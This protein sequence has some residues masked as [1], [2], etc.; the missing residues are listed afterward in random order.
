MRTSKHVLLGLTIAAAAL[1]S[2]CGEGDGKSCTLHSDCGDLE[3]YMCFDDKC[4]L[5]PSIH[6]TDGELN[7][8]ETD[9]DCGGA[10]SSKCAVSQIC[11]INEDCDSG[12]CTN[13]RCIMKPCTLDSECPSNQCDKDKGIC[14]SC[15]DGA[16][17]G[18]E[19]DV[20]CGGKCAPCAKGKACLMPTDCQ[21]ENCTDNV[22]VGDPV[23]C[24]A[25]TL[26]DLVINEVLGSPDTA[27]P[28]ATSVSSQ[29]EFVEIVNTSNKRLDLS[30]VTLQLTKVTDSKLTSIA[31]SGC[32]AAK[33]AVVVAEG[34]IEG[35][36]SDVLWIN[37]KTAITN[38]ADYSLNLMIGDLLGESILR[39]KTTSNG[40]SQTRIPDITGGDFQLHNNALSKLVNSPGFC[41]NGGIFSKDCAIIDRCADGVK[42]DDETGVDCGGPKCAGCDDG[43]ACMQASDCLSD[44][45]EGNVCV[46]S[47]YSRPE[48]G[49]I[50]IAEVFNNVTSSSPMSVY[51][52]EV[53]TQMQV[54]YF[55]IVNLSSKALNLNGIQISTTRT[56]ATGTLAIQTLSGT[57]DPFQVIVVSDLEILGLPE[58]VKSLPLGFGNNYIT[59]TWV[60]EFSLIDNKGNVLHTAST[61]EQD[62][63]TISKALKTLSASDTELVSHN[64]I[65]QKLKHSPGYCSNGGLYVDKCRVNI[66]CANDIL[67]DDETDVD[68]G[69]PNCKA[70]S[71]GES[72]VVNEDCESSYCDNNL[73]ALSPY[74]KPVI[75]D[76][77]IAEVLNHSNTTGTLTCHD[78]SINNQP[79][80]EYYE[81]VN[82]SDKNI[83]LS[84]LKI[85]MKRLDSA[86]PSYAPQKLSG[87]LAPY[88]AVVVS[89]QKIGCLPEGVKS[90]ALG[91][92][93]NF[94]TNT[95]V[96]EI[97]LIDSEGLVLHTVSTSENDDKNKGIS[98]VIETLSTLSTNLVLHTDVG[99]N[100]ANSPGYCS[101]G[102]LYA[103][104]CMVIDLCANEVLDKDETDIDCGGPNCGACAN[105]KTCIENKDCESGYCG[106]KVCATSPYKK[107][108]AGDLIISE[109]LNNA[110]KDTPMAVYD[111]SVTNQL[112]AEYF[113]IVNLSDSVLDLNGV[114]ITSTR[115]NAT[116]DLA[117]QTL[118][119]TLEAHQAI[120]VSDQTILGLP[121]GVKSLAL[122]FGTNFIT[123]TGT[124]T[125]ELKDNEGNVLHT[126]KTIEADSAASVSKALETLDAT[127]DILKI[128]PEI[129]INDKN[130]QY[131][132]GYCSNGKLF[133]NSCL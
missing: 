5:L 20:D 109:V 31:L 129:G 15:H 23:A 25:P 39:A 38:S 74:Q 55:E 131:S 94:I 106:S 42:N 48:V 11:K 28:F 99:K 52:S 76:L 102:G 83:D 63:S 65:N 122:E 120:V 70:C 81:I 57:L 110:K 67:D 66:L 37:G 111:S 77:V 114:Q 87:F 40:T 125:F 18:N 108:V 112:Q 117:V 1:F 69:G 115:T 82:L 33:S 90:L 50:V 17:N 100:L 43:Q 59:N 9:V 10:C 34:P 7:E 22:C 47:A 36:P 91:F 60:A 14:V 97:R 21:S 4:T 80:M 92:G 116:G 124:F 29:V 64:V 85:E 78:T 95:A 32:V 93:S 107:P 2:A 44:S 46:A 45:C 113:E 133:V 127:N 98:K 41:N 49:D 119:G 79:Q 3:K 19:T 51:D 75:G 88:Q 84:G 86:K 62:V 123:N 72:C 104:K 89:D 128:H 105:G 96:L 130:V 132:P 58:G 103:E 118:S 73:C 126:A 8:S 30:G 68:C 16:K 56:D 13:G 27:K 71:V 54:E 61:V 12:L 53:T 101:N 24:E 121:E 6:C 26:T 35:M